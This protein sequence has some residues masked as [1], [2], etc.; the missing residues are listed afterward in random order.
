MNDERQGI[1]AV[2]EIPVVIRRGSEAQYDHAVAK[3]A[4]RREALQEV[5]AYV[6]SVL[7]TAGPYDDIRSL[8]DLKVHLADMIRSLPA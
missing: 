3:C 5:D 2:G 7:A 4:G 1:E 8:Q 6:D